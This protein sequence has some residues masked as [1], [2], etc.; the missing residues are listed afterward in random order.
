MPAKKGQT[1]RCMIFLDMIFAVD[2]IFV[3]HNIFLNIVCCAEDGQEKRNE[4][5]PENNLQYTTVYVGN[6]AAEVS[7]C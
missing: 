1:S 4:D 5:A 2:Y 7:I 3:L 6:L